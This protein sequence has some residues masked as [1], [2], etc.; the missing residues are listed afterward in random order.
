M[1]RKMLANRHSG[2]SS[3]DNDHSGKDRPEFSRPFAVDRLGAAA[4]NETIIATAKE[5]ERVAERLGLLAVDQFA[6]TARL[7]RRDSSGVVHVSGRLEADVVQTCIVTL[8]A[9][10]S[11]VEDSFE[12]DFSAE[13]PDAGGEF[14]FDLD[15]EPPEPIVGGE[16]DLGELVTQYLSLA[17]DPY[18]RAPGVTFNPVLVAPAEPLS[19]FAAL[20]NLKPRG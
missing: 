18:P 15:S 10:P 16:I 14:V 3:S 9:F 17:L 6:A 4:V 1:P 2:K 7:E 19:P 20:G 12:T 11:H 13:M 5:R 8:T